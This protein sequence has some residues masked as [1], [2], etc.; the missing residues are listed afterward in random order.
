MII[1]IAAALAARTKRVITVVLDDD[2]TG[3]QAEA[4]V[5]LLLDW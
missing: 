3:A 1:D 4:D 2:P 5:P